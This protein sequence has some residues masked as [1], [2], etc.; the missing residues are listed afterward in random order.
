MSG[1]L[2]VD[3]DSFRTTGKIHPHGSE[4]VVEERAD[5]VYG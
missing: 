3:D 4:R 1:P 2:R 5:G